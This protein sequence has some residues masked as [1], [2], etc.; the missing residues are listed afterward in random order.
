MFWDSILDFS[1]KQAVLD[2]HGI[3]TDNNSRYDYIEYDRNMNPHDFHV[4]R[5]DAASTGC[6]TE[7]QKVQEGRR[8]LSG[9]CLAKL[10]I[11]GNVFWRNSINSPDYFET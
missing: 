10:A 5:A 8:F 7:S 3:Q 1:A 4:A 2:E 6:C 11:Y 9:H